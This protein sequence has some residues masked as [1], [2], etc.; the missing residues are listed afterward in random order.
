M[1]GRIDTLG[2]R[3]I[4]EELPPLGGVITLGLNA[5]LDGWRY[6]LIVVEF[7]GDGAAYTASADGIENLP[8]VARHLAGELRKDRTPGLTA[9]P[10]DDQSTLTVS[11]AKK[12]ALLVRSLGE[13]LPTIVPPGWGFGLLLYDF[14]TRGGRAWISSIADESEIVTLE[15]FARMCETG[16]GRLAGVVGREN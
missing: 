12:L 13:M 3:L 6:L 9:A 7:D 5:I 2:L 4:E 14:R 16:R 8:E 1:K 11:Q 10:V 15:E